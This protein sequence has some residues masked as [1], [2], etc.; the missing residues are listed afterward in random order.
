MRGICVF[1][2]GVKEQDGNLVAAQGVYQEY[3]IAR[4]FGNTLIPVAFT[5]GTAVEIWAHL[6]AT[7]GAAAAKLSEDI[8]SRLGITKATINDAFG[9]VGDAIEEAI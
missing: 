3:E 2:G 5:G 7:G 4:R 6:N 9:I 1:I 8:F